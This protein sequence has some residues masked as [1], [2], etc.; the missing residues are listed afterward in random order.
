[1]IGEFLSHPQVFWALFSIGLMVAT[2]LAF[3]AKKDTV[4]HFWFVFRAV[5]SAVLGMGIIIGLYY[6]SAPEG[7]Q[8]SFEYAPNSILMLGV[9]FLSGMFF[10]QIM[11]NRET[12]QKA[13]GAWLKKKLLPFVPAVISKEDNPMPAGPPNEMVA[14]IDTP[15]NV[16][17]VAEEA[18][19]LR[20]NTPTP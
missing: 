6:V 11:E 14:R 10:D 19:A 15:P 20:E 13:F 1:M 18:K 17:Q 2:S 12:L 8:A 16:K 9:C 7:K 4:A 5:Q 3:A